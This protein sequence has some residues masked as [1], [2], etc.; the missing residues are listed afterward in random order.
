MNNNRKPILYKGELYAKPV[1]KKSG[2]GSKNLPA[3]FQEAKKKIKNDIEQVF[4]EIDR[5]P[6][7][8]RMPNEIVVCMRM[9]S[10]F[11]LKVIIRI[12]FLTQ[13][14]KSLDYRR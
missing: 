11:R 5:L 14:M 4:E 3:T 12:L 8:A 10:D 2:G 9:H 6:E 1:T 7:I 13:S